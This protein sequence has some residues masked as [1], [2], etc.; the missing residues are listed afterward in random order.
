MNLAELKAEAI[1]IIKAKPELK[2]DIQEFYS[3]A[4]SEIEEGGSE[5]HECSLAYNDML[6]LENGT[7]YED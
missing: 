2:S 6:A 5:S 7:Y 4:I 3:L 1:R